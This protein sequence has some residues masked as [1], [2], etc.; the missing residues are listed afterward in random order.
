MRALARA[1]SY[2][3]EV[4]VSKDGGL[5]HYTAAFEDSIL[6]DTAQTITEAAGEIVAFIAL[7]AARKG[8][9]VGVVRDIAE[10]LAVAVALETGQQSKKVYRDL[11]Q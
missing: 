10:T 2:P 6:S 8:Y 7:W 9:T 4:A 5:Y 1:I 11:I 3:A